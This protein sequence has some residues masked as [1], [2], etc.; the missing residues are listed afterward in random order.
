[1]TALRITLLIIALLFISCERSTDPAIYGAPVTATV[2]VD[3][4]TF[5]GY[6]QRS[7]L[8]LSDTL[9]GTFTVENASGAQRTYG[10]A[11]IQQVG[12]ELIGS[13]GKTA[14]F[15]PVLVSPATSQLVLL[16]GEKKVYAIESLLKD[17]NGSLIPTGS[18]QC[19]IHLLD[20]NSPAVALPIVVQ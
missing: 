19:S 1:M 15:Q 7:A 9:Q 16:N 13:N 3:G 8:G 2:T 20:G 5:T 4:I 11:N 17:F 12:F 10:F 18:Y 6:L 14:L